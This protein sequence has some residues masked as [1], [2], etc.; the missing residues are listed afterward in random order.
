MC[1]SMWLVF[2]LWFLSQVIW[3][4][5]PLGRNF[6]FSVVLWFSWTYSLLVFKAR[7]LGGLMFPLQD[8]WVGCLMELEP[9]SSG[10]S[11][12]PLW[13][14]LLVGCHIGLCFFPWWAVSLPLLPVLTLS[15]CPLLWR[16][17]SSSFQIPFWGNYCSC[18]FAVSIRNYM[19]L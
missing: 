18:R 4:V 17:W 7:C 12:V 8:F 19:Q 2:L 3:G 6:S 14:L 13:S 10:E 1:F 15:F 11:H 16:L 5:G 9:H